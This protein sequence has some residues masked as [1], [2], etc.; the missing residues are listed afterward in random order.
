MN[1]LACR[2]TATLLMVALASCGG[3]GSGGE[4]AIGLPAGQSPSS[5]SISDPVS[6]P[7]VT[8]KAELQD[9]SGIQGLSA[10]Q[11]D[12]S[13]GVAALRGQGLDALSERAQ[14]RGAD[15]GSVS[16]RFV[17][18]GDPE[19]YVGSWSASDGSPARYLLVA[20]GPDAFDTGILFEPLTQSEQAT[21]GA[22]VRLNDATLTGNGATQNINGDASFAIG[23]WVTGT[24]TLGPG[25][26]YVLTGDYKRTYHYLAFNAVPYIPPWDN[27]PPLICSTGAFTT[28]THLDSG[29]SNAP[30]N[31]T[32]TGSAA[33][34]FNHGEAHITGAIKVMA[35][36]EAGTVPFSTGDH[37]L[38]SSLSW[39]SAFS[40]DNTTG[41]W[42]V[43]FMLGDGE[44]YGT[45][46]IAIKYIAV[47]LPSRARYTGV[48]SLSC[49]PTP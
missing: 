39:Q 21:N 19:R 22:M 23:R 40:T 32:A 42:S 49:R 31:G 4:S 28:P 14:M 25:K 11:A 26:N 30:L 35:G 27:A 10:A 45:K 12:S 6:T 20:S 46:M 15:S 37:P 29:P 13:G 33:I 36:D 24:A 18:G 43:S 17:P 16:A 2:A 8:A 34:S 48:A 41:R 5:Q 9:S 7:A 38:N 1:K 47:M 44:I 3:G